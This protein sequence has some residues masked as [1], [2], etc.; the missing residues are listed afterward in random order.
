MTAYSDLKLLIGLAIAALMAWKLTVASAIRMDIAPARPKIHHS[1]WMRYA[2]FSS[3]LFIEIQAMGI[4]TTRASSTRR[5]N[6]PDNCTNRTPTL[7]PST[8]RILISLARRSAVNIARPR[9]PMQDIK[10]AKTAK[11]LESCFTTCSLR[12]K[13]W[14]SSSEKNQV[15]GNWGFRFLAIFARPAKASVVLPGWVRTSADP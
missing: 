6:S 9:R 13:R 4:A 14:Y 1:I 12:Y 7:A 5:I 15:K 10:I 2:N 11:A 8:F 3:Q